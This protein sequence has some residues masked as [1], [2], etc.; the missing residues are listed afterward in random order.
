[1]AA[2]ER[3]RQVFLAGRETV[4]DVLAVASDAK[5]QMDSVQAEVEALSQRLADV[6]DAFAMVHAIAKQTDLLAINAAI[7]AAHAGDAGR[8][9]AVVADAVRELSGQSQRTAKS[10]HSVLEAA[11]APIARLQE[12]VARTRSLAEQNAE[13]GRLLRSWLDEMSAL[14]K[15]RDESPSGL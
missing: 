15:T 3:L 1:M 2:D 5:T 9:F 4:K 7:E 10:V 8:G 13:N 6:Q 14:W 11:A 12:A